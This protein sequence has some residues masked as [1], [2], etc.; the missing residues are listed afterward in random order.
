MFRRG[1]STKAD[2]GRGYGLYNLRRLAEKSSGKVVAKNETIDG[3][4]HLTIGI[5]I[6]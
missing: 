1:Y 5:I 2:R 4:N 6:P 3:T